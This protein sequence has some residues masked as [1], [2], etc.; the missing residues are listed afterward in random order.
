MS[1]CVV[2]SAR[3]LPVVGGVFTVDDV[4]SSS[5]PLLAVFSACG[6]RA[7]ACE[8]CRAVTWRDTICLSHIHSLS[9]FIVEAPT[10]R[11]NEACT[12][13]IN[14]K[15]SFTTD[16]FTACSFCLIELWSINLL[17]FLWLAAYVCQLY[18]GSL[19]Q[20]MKDIASCRPIIDFSSW[21][22][23]IASLWWFPTS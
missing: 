15:F 16:T 11:Y 12:I 22:E 19:F 6:G 17:L 21:S 20:K 2:E 1:A 7:W 9:A 3:Q 8:A 4:L 13:H 18:R 14:F 5:K 10:L 23:T